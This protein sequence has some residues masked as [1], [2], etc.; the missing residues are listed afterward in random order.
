MGS[1]GKFSVPEATHLNFP[2]EFPIF[3]KQPNVRIEVLVHDQAE[4]TLEELDIIPTEPHTHTSQQN[5]NDHN[6]I[7]Y[8]IRNSLVW[9][10]SLQPGLLDNGVGC[11]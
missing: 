10:V 8:E 1:A 9:V 2:E 6:G 11:E 5:T 4:V 7:R 3:S